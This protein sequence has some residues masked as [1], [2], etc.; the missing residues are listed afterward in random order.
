MEELIKPALDG[1]RNILQTVNETDSVQRVV[2][3][4]SMVA[5]YA[6]SCDLINTKDGIFTEK[7]WNKTSSVNHQPYPHSKTLAEKE[8]WK[9]ANEQN[10]WDLVVINPGFIL[11]PSLSKRT[12]STSVN[13]MLE[14]TSGKFKTGVPAGT[15]ANV[16]VRDVAKAHILAGYTP[17][18]SGR[19][20]AASHEGDFLDIAKTIKTKYPSLPLPKG[21]V[22]KWLFKLIAP[23]IGFSR[24]YVANNVGY[25]IKFDNSYIKKNLGIEFMPFEKTI[26]DFMDQLINDELIKVK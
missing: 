25:N 11:G 3:T 20:I 18:A 12:D 7:H 13:L 2:L 8:A 5:I 10:R 14:L 19:H 6:D 21:Y 15:H 22:P 26:H 16:D 4:S 1:T 23:K 17:T 9:I 24:K